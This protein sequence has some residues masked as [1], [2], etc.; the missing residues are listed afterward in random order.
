MSFCV[1]WFFPIYKTQLRLLFY[2][3]FL[4]RDCMPSM[5]RPTKQAP[6]RRAAVERKKAEFNNSNVT[7]QYGPKSGDFFLKY[8]SGLPKNSQILAQSSHKTIQ[9]TA[10][11]YGDDDIFWNENILKLVSS[12]ESRW[13]TTELGGCSHH[14]ALC[15]SFVWQLGDLTVNSTDWLGPIWARKEFT[16][17][18]ASRLFRKS[19]AR[20][21]KL[22]PTATK[23]QD[24]LGCRKHSQEHVTAIA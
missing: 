4:C 13:G 12:L 14:P 7:T 15:S 18:N 20:P 1:S 16:G 5:R 10:G 9:E 11:R 6:V 2:L 24:R 23:G 21:G 17:S 8:W 19:A 22:A 3:G